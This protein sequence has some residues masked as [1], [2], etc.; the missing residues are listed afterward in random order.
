M[1]HAMDE[2][3]IKFECVWIEGPPPPL[4]AVRDLVAARDLLHAL[5]LVGEYPDGIGFGNVSVRSGAEII[6]TGTQTGGVETITP[7]ELTR[8][9][10]YDIERN[11][12]TCIGPLKASSE[13]LTH[14][15]IYECDRSIG[16]V[17][18]VHSLEAW[19]RL[20]GRIPTTR[21][22]VAYGT[23]AMAHELRRL[24]HESDLPSSRVAAMAG[25]PEGIIGFGA[26]IAE[27]LD[28]VL[29]AVE[30]AR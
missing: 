24:Y 27:A 21:E 19:E 17:V 11:R 26:T 8:V 25:H 3:Y 2:G 5:D 6:I 7:R 28:A 23:P 20:V 22:E 30:V 29:E 16:A 18:H 1:S 13:S 14:A 9:V 12:V 15:A 10:G 4:D